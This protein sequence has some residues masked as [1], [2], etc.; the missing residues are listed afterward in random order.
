M[1]NLTDKFQVPG[2]ILIDKYLSESFMIVDDFEEDKITI[3]RGVI[4]ER[5]NLGIAKRY[6]ITETGI[7]PRV[8]PGTKG[9][10]VKSTG[11]EH[12]EYGFTTEDEKIASMMA[13]KRWKKF[14]LMVEE[15]KKY[16]P[17]KVHGN[18]NGKTLLITWGST[19]GPVVEA[20]KMLAKENIDV[21]IIQIV[22]MSPFPG[23]ELLE[24]I[25]NA[26][27]VIIIEMNKTGILKGLIREHC[28]VNIEHSIRKYGGRPFNP[29]EIA[30]KVKEILN[31]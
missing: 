8:F 24:E 29:G 12:D 27:N 4:D 15:M 11:D 7:S 21:K 28:L 23:K 25:K 1:F 17:I 22:F 5:E 20:S 14:P 9:V 10:I 3:E 16:H 26:E 19:R 18:P 30:A 31:K 6:A 2:I 13:D